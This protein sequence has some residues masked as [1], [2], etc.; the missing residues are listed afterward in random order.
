MIL[1]KVISGGQTGVD[2]AALDAATES[3]ISIGGFCPKDRRSEDREIPKKYPMIETE[4]RAYHVRTKRNVIEA[5]GTLILTIGSLSGGTKLT[6]AYAEIHNKPSLIVH[7]DSKVD[8][9]EVA[10][11]IISNEIKILNIAGPRESGVIGGIYALAH[12]FLMD[13]FDSMGRHS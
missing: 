12:A 3:N 13:L 8:L 10:G 1:N 4:S 7:L 11:W 9:N 6:A 5:D 2:R